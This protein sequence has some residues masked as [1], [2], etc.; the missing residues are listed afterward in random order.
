MSWVKRVFGL[1]AFDLGLQALVTGVVL[2]WISEAN[3]HNDAVIMGSM[4]SIASLVVLG[5]RRRLALR[6][7]ERRIAGEFD[8]QRL[9]ELE[10]RVAEL[11]LDRARI[12]ELEERL[13]FTERLLA[14]NKDA[15][16]ELA[17]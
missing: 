11:E 2:F 13:D 16:R 7:G 15:V 17:P 10:L 9:A 5:I 12:A 4:A 14:T 3:S 6:G 1:D 8:E